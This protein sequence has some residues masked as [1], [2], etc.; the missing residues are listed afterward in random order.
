MAIQEAKLVLGSRAIEGLLP[1]L[2]AVKLR[3]GCRFA[4]CSVRL[5]ALITSVIMEAFLVRV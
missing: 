3:D 5:K 4:E 2:L 1:E